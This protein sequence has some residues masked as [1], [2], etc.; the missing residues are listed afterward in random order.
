MEG[1]FFTKKKWLELMEGS[2]LYISDELG[3]HYQGTFNDD[4]DCRH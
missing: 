2:R 4:K 1:K 3:R